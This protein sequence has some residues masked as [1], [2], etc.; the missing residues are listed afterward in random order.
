MSLNRTEHELHE[1]AALIRAA[2]GRERVLPSIS[3]HA[4]G[5]RY[6]CIGVLKMQE[7]K[8][9]SDR[10][11]TRVRVQKI[12][13]IPVREENVWIVDRRFLEHSIREIDSLGLS[14][15]L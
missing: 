7:T 9:T 11:K 10:V 4:I 13:R 8:R 1:I 14:P 3:K 12:L 5:L 2:P 6:R 15:S